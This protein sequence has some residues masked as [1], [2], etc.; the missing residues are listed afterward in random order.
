MA[1]SPDVALDLLRQAKAARQVGDVGVARAVFAKAY[2]AARQVRDVEAM[3]EAALGLAADHKFG[4]HPGRV[5]A[6][7][8]E[9]YGSAD[10]VARTRL[11]A[12]L[13]RAWVYGGS[14]ERG[15]E[16]AAEA[17]AG[18][19]AAGD[20]ALLAEALD[21]QLLVHWGPDDL[22]ERLRITARLED[23]VAHVA[24]V[25]SRMTAHLWRL[26]TAV[27]GL[28]MPSVRRQLRALERLADESG[29][30]RV[31]FFAESRKAMHATVI[32]DLDTAR[33]H[34]D[35]AV[36]AG[37]E[38]GEADTF[39]I[40]H[41]LAA[42]IARQND[43]TDSLATEAALAEEF[44]AAEGYL[45]LAVEAAAL[46]VAAGALERA[47]S[48]LL[49]TV[50]SGLAAVRRDVDWLLIVAR[51]TETAA[52]TGELDL[53]AEGYALLEP[54]A[55]R[56]IPN[57]GAAIF[58]GI[59]DGFLSEAA[60]ALGRH[61]DATQWARHAASLAQRFG[62]AWWVREFSGNGGVAASPSQR[63]ST[64]VLQPGVAGVWT[65][66]R[67]TQTVAVREMKG[68]HYLRILLQQPGIE[69]SA[70]DLSDWVAGHPGRSVHDTGYGE[71]IDRQ[72]LA[73]YRTRISEVDAELAE[74]EEW[75]DDGRI[76]RLRG[77]RDA[78]L[79]EVAAATGLGGRS[80]QRGT[81]AER[82]RVA[83][84]KA[85]AAAIDHLTEIDATL[86]RV[87]N[88]CVRTGTTCRY[89]PDPTRPL[90]WVTSHE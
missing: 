2:D 79:D 22:A 62:A 1:G 76:A 90:T 64:A 48:L 85:I 65:V 60:D 45:T 14:P 10:G 9:A 11:A 16:F 42:V 6:F 31:R 68:F 51:A 63:P 20:L 47:R 39:A 84:R 40:N 35:S 61:G 66:G 15:V 43:D 89:D 29:S 72:A 53:A 58:D 4:T 27:E 13:V 21:A 54:Y 5:P 34:R 70:L 69:I 71:I 33:A 7:L 19:E 44:A 55:G 78:L 50:G 77:E 52:K 75:A 86:G 88:D 82:A 12:A 46:W 81:A 26:T 41:A 24:D 56:G 18:A 80:R 38:A 67:D 32:G 28:D 30:A 17:V 59:V 74:A 83:V 73:A 87:L 49:Q 8:F 3:S 36:R 37:T 25:E 57:A 23:A